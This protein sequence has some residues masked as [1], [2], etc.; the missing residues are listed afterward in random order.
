MVEKIVKVRDA[1]GLTNARHTFPLLGTDQN[2]GEPL[3][4]L[5]DLIQIILQL[6]VREREQDASVHDKLQVPCSTVRILDKPIGTMNLRF[7]A[8]II[9]KIGLRLQAHHA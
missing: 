9:S 3:L 6:L 7:R 1:Y 4:Q 5:T 8:E 2:R